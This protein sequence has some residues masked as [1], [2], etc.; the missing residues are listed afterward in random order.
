MYSRLSSRFVKTS[1]PRGLPGV[2]SKNP[3]I[4][5]AT[6]AAAWKALQTAR[7]E[8]LENTIAEAAALRDLINAGVSGC[9]CSTLGECAIM[10]GISTPKPA[11]SQGHEQLQIENP[12]R[13][14]PR[15]GPGVTEM[16][17]DTGKQHAKRERFDY[18]VNRA[19][20][21]SCDDI[22]V[23]TAGSDDNDR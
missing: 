4:G 15:D 23:R 7:L 3:T 17:T 21:E 20:V 9:G 8:A 5:S 14:Y 12:L 16:G 13:L 19:A 1:Q 10:L 18:D 11:R 6:R 2:S 22:D